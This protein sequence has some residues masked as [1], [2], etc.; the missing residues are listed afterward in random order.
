[1]T[2]PLRVSLLAVGGVLA[3]AVVFFA[4]GA[5]VDPAVLVLALSC[6]GVGVNARASASVSVR[7]LDG[8]AVLAAGYAVA[9]LMVHASGLALPV[10]LLTFVVAVAAA[11]ALHAV[12][13]GGST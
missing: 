5:R 7:L 6:F 9:L 1:M 3:L 12:Q 13:S 11:G 10:V 2:R 4:L 8:A